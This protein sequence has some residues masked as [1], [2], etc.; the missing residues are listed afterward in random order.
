[1]EGNKLI[2]AL[3]YFSVLFAPFLFPLI[4]YFVTKQARVKQHAKASFLSHCIPV[5]LFVFS[6]IMVI[7]LGMSQNDAFFGW[8]LLGALGGGLAHVIVAVWNIIK[9]IKVLQ[10]TGGNYQ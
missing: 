4:V 6:A 3:C 5:A 2:A 9:G 8:W 7:V 10:E 1:M